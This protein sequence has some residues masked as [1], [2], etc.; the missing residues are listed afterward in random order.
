MAYLFIYLSHWKGTRSF[1]VY[2]VAVQITECYFFLSYMQT[3]RLANPDHLW[4]NN[5]VKQRNGPVNNSFPTIVFYRVRSEERGMEVQLT[6][7][8]YFTHVPQLRTSLMCPLT[9]FTTD[10]MRCPS[11]EPPVRSSGCP[12]YRC[13]GYPWLLLRKVLISRQKY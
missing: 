10:E 9:G 1:Q 8:P 3:E 5:N 2:M 6:T 4:Y 11:W 13:T 12:L 7:T